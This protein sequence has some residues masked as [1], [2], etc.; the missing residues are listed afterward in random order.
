MSVFK[1]MSIQINYQTGSFKK[2][3]SNSVL[4][5]D[6]NF[7]ITGLKK[8]ITSKDYS[9]IKDLLANNNKKKKNNCL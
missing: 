2:N 6:E 5:V 1:F 8:F 9:F 4:F 7:N 3:S